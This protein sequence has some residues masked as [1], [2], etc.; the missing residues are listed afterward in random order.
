MGSAIDLESDGTSQQAEVL[1]FGLPAMI[2]STKAVFLRDLGTAHRC[3]WPAP[4]NLILHDI[5]LAAAPDIAAMSVSGG[6]VPRSN[7]EHACK[8]PRSITR[9]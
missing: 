2:L 9:Q 8:S 6:K 4:E 7:N 5:E 3:D 1:S